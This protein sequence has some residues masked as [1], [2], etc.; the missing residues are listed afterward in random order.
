MYRYDLALSMLSVLNILV[1]R[2]P[3]LEYRVEEVSLARHIRRK[4]SSYAA[5]RN[6]RSGGGPYICLFSLNLICAVTNAVGGDCSGNLL[7][8]FVHIHYI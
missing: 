2:L 7:E 1:L 3:F 4:L 5:T 8:R 6:D